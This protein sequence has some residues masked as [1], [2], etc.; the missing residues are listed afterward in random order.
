ML[1]LP[2]LLTIRVDESLTYLNARWLE[3][4]V[5]EQVA[6]RPALRHVVLMASAVNAIDASGLESLEAINHRLE[7]GGIRLHLSEVKGPVMD[8]LKRSHFLDDLSGRVFLSQDAAFA[9]LAQD[10]GEASP[11]PLAD[12]ARGLI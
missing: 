9:E 11:S 1:T 6:A 8:R 3:E 10:T 12:E 5:L 4:Y 7:D 2:H